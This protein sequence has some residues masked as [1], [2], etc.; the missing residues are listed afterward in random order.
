M[1][2]T[3]TACLGH[4]HSAQT[5]WHWLLLTLGLEDS[6]ATELLGAPSP[7]PLQGY[8]CQGMCCYQLAF[9]PYPS[10]LKA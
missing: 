9:D 7:C 4:A 3:Q 5:L 1:G 10:D 2:S 8:T 6:G